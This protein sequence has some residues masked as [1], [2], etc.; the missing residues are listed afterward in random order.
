MSVTRRLQQQAERL[1][2]QNGTMARI[3]ERARILN[4]EARKL[5]YADA[6]A[7]YKVLGKSFIDSVKRNNPE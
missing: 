3:A 1:L 6:S 7:A 4:L 2:H 5:G